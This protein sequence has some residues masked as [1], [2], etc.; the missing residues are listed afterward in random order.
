VIY[1]AL[2]HCHNPATRATRA[3]DPADTT[4]ATFHGAWDSDA[5]IALL[6][7]AI[8]WGVSA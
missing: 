1:V 3:A 2:G 7:N 5:F 4:P 8:A 6:Q